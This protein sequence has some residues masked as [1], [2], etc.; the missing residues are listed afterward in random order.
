MQ[1]FLHRSGEMVSPQPES[2]PELWTLMIE[3]GWRSVVNK[4]E[5]SQ[6][7]DYL[8]YH[9]DSKINIF[10]IVVLLLS[11]G[12]EVTPSH[13]HSAFLRGDTRVRDL[14]FKK[15]DRKLLADCR[16]LHRAVGGNHI[17]MAEWL[18]DIAKMDVNIIPT[19]VPA[20]HVWE[21]LPVSYPGPPIKGVNGTP[22]HYAIDVNKKAMA[23]LLLGRGANTNIKNEDGETAWDLAQ[24][25]GA[26]YML[27]MMMFHEKVLKL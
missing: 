5:L 22:L 4:D 15:I 18:I 7:L 19:D 8:L 24:R 6:S 14:L 11:Y 16:L 17:K 10:G 21:D 26:W 12:V 27:G 1:E 9:S 25:K 13:L 23:R 20:T 3:H 2:S